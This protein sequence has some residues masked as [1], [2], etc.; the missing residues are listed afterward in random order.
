MFLLLRKENRTIA[1]QAK[2][3]GN[4]V[5]VKAVHWVSATKWYYRTN[6]EWVITN[7]TFTKNVCNC[8]ERLSVRLID[9]SD[10]IN[11]IPE[12]KA[13]H[14]GTGIAPSGLIRRGYFI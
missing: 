6:E 12:S 11:L 13:I 8:A 9:R 10:L 5:G 3:Y 7:N 2:R 1:V 14:S 4:A